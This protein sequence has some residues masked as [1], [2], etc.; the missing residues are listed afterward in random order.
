MNIIESAFLGVIQG[1]GEFLPISSSAHLVIFPYLLNIKYQGLQFDVILHIGTLFAIIIFFFKDWL[2]I[3]KDAYQKPKSNEGKLLWHL[4]IATIPAGLIGLLFEKQAEEI[5]RNPLLIGLN[6]IFFSAFIYLSD[7]KAKEYLSAENF[8][9]KSALIIGL[10]QAIAI[11]PGASRSGMTIMA[12]LFLGYKRHDSARISFLM[13]TPIIFGAG[14]LELRKLNIHQM[15]INLIT[16]LL[17]SFIFGILSIK[18]L[19]DYLKK[20]DLKIF[21]V[22][23]VILGL[24][25]ILKYILN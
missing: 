25:V 4:V 22:Y 1:I 24:V 15:D 7:R 3:F 13:A 17:I 6:L 5:F 18:F 14:I 19:L 21:I 12:A 16:A 11:L 23:R 9:I 10:A 8:N 2:K 20:K